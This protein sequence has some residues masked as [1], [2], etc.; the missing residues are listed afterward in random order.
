MGGKGVH[1]RARCQA[2]QLGVCQHSSPP[3]NRRSSSLGGSVRPGPTPRSRRINFYLS[4]ADDDDGDREGGGGRG[5]TTSANHRRSYA[6]NQGSRGIVLKPRTVS[7]PTSSRNN[8]MQNPWGRN[9]STTNSSSTWNGDIVTENRPNP[10]DGVN[11][12]IMHDSSIAATVFDRRDHS[13]G[14][15]RTVASSIVDERRSS[16]IGSRTT[17]SAAISNRRRTLPGNSS[18]TT[19]PATSDR[20][21]P[22]NGNQTNATQSTTAY[23]ENLPQSESLCNIL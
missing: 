13:S 18:T 4:F 15:S 23:R 10:W 16:L 22:F 12:S 19:Q 2:C 21:R 8:Q 6:T 14:N 1:D 17:Q 7:T 3:S 5:R 11:P 20:R 9:R